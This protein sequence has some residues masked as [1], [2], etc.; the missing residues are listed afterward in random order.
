MASI[1]RI[2]TLHFAQIDY[3]INLS[4][5]LFFWYLVEIWCNAIRRHLAIRWFQ[6]SAQIRHTVSRVLA[7]FNFGNG[8]LY[9]IL[10]A[11]TGNESGNYLVRF[12][13]N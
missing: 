6:T 10:V 3:N 2:A 1:Y 5:H 7:S 8:S 4:L 11:F 9:K 12:Q 13:F